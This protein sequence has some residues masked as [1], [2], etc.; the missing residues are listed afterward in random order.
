MSGGFGKQKEGQISTSQAK[1]LVLAFE[2]QIVKK[3]ADAEDTERFF[4]RREVE[5]NEKLLEQLPILF[6]RLTGNS[7]EK[8]QQLGVLLVT[9]GAALNQV[10]VGNRQLNIEI[11][12]RCCQLGLEAFSKRNDA[13]NWARVQHNLG[14]AYDERIRG[15]R[16][17]N[18]E[19]SLLEKL[20]DA[21]LAIRN[22]LGYA[23]EFEPLHVDLPFSE[24]P[25]P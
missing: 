17:E 23:T 20:E 11:F 2:A 25:N 6:R 5:I 10:P 13:Q 8:R 18:L 4:E 14:T 1:K 3:E 19:Q 9:L 12:L 16:A 21:D 24:F 15:E 22:E 7:P